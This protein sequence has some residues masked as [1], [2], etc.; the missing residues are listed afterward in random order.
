MVVVEEGWR[1]LRRSV[2]AE[3]SLAAE[4]KAA[5]EVYFYCIY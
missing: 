4:E 1:P 3:G 5:T 2:G